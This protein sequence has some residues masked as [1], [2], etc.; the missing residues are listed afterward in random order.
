MFFWT[1]WHLPGHR[2]R[3]VELVG[4]LFPAA[5]GMRRVLGVLSAWRAASCICGALFATGPSKTQRLERTRAL[6]LIPTQSLMGL[7]RALLLACG[8]GPQGSWR[9]MLDATHT[10]SLFALKEVQLSS[11]LLLGVCAS[12]PF[13]RSLALSFCHSCALCVCLKYVR[14]FQSATAA[15]QQPPGQAR[16]PWAWPV[17]ALLSRV[18]LSCHGEEGIMEIRVVLEAVCWTAFSLF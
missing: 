17:C 1:A 4:G 10:L 14:V 11:L 12:L 18:L 5:L 16:Q 6:A 13:S 2:H 8:V 7:E 3:S 15:P 9:W